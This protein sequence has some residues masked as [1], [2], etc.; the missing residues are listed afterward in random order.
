MLLAHDPAPACAQATNP[1][2]TEVSG[3]VTHIRP[4]DGARYEHG[5]GATDIDLEGGGGGTVTYAE[6]AMEA[7]VNPHRGMAFSMPPINLE[8]FE[9]AG[10]QAV[11]KHLDQAMKC[12]EAAKSDG[13]FLDSGVPSDVE[14]PVHIKNIGRWLDAASQ[15]IEHLSESGRVEMIS[16]LGGEPQMRTRLQNMDVQ[17]RIFNAFVLFYKGYSSSDYKT[18]VQHL[19]G[20][21]NMGE[22]DN[23]DLRLLR[24]KAYTVMG[25]PPPSRMPRLVQFPVHVDDYV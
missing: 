6:P 9:V 4:D 13:Y 7:T 21:I 22:E 16:E 20:A 19:T 1:A 12:F 24:A 23:V 11:K 18:V 5:G 10:A 25:P 17:L 15:M 8:L 3:G 2:D 14:M